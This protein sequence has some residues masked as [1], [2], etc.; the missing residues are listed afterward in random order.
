MEPYRPI[1]III[2]INYI[3]NSGIGNCSELGGTLSYQDTICMVRIIS[4][5]VTHKTRGLR[6][7]YPFVPV[8]HAY[9]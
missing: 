2:L 1:I 6:P 7:S 3:I 4:Y 9:D 8:F 5:E